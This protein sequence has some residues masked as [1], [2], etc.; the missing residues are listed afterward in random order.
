MTRIPTF[1]RSPL[2]SKDAGI[3]SFA[4]VAGDVHVVW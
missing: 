1:H 4:E 2:V 3:R